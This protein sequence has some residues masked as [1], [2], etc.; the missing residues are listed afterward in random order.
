[1]STNF[2][3]YLCCLLAIIAGF[4]IVKKVAGCLIKSIVMI[5]IIAI[6]AFLYVHYIR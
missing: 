6:L 1:M 2:I 5:V 3:Y 4:L